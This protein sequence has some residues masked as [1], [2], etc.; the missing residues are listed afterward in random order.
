MI[1][2]DNRNTLMYEVIGSVIYTNFDEYICLD[3]LVLIQENL[4]KHDNNFKNIKFNNLSGLVITDIFMNIMSCHGFVKY[5]I[6]TLILT[7][8]NDQVPSDI[9]KVFFIFETEVG[10]VDNIPIIVKKNQ[11]YSFE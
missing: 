5:S 8:S 4:S 6:S 3:D 11:C 7:F 10:G 2:Y 1:F 9:Y